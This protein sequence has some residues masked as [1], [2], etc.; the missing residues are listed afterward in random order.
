MMEETRSVWNRARQSESQQQDNYISDTPA[1]WSSLELRT[2][3]PG[4]VERS[5]PTS[6]RSRDTERGIESIVGR[7]KRIKSGAGNRAAHVCLSRV[8]REHAETTRVTEL[9]TRAGRIMI[10]LPRL[11]RRGNLSRAIGR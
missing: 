10:S 6:H 11:I 8:E 4:G 9:I 1:N 2:L 7:K 3:L 5:R